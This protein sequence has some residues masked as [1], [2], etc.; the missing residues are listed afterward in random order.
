MP[1]AQSGGIVEDGKLASRVLRPL[2]RQRDAGAQ[3]GRASVELRQQL[4]LDP[5]FFRKVGFVEL[6]IFHDLIAGE[7]ARPVYSRV[8]RQLD[9]VSIQVARASADLAS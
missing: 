8:E 9:G 4:R 7:S 6:A 5:H 2:F 1:A 3:I